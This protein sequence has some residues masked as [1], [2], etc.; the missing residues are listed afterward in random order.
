MATDPLD[1]PPGSL[2][3]QAIE[4][5]LEGGG[6]GGIPGG[7]TS[8]LQYNNAGAFGGVAESTY[9]PASHLLTIADPNLDFEVFSGPAEQNGIIVS[10][11]G[12][13]VQAGE[14]GSFIQLNADSDIDVSSS[15]GDFNLSSANGG[16]EISNAGTVLLSSTASPPKY[17][18][19]NL[20]VFANN[21]AAI[22][23]G[24]T[25]GN[26]YRT[27]ANPDPVCIVH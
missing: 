21:A 19:F 16:I 25:A 7:A 6:G 18:I 11:G 4:L 8:Q 13:T 15:N 24:L 5:L 12:L 3:L 14:S 23:G 1:V 27:G 22:A 2:Q 9:V 10:D 26:L 20:P 17:S